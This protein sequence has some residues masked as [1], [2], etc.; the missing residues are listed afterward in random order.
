MSDYRD[1]RDPVYRDPVQDPAYEA[2]NPRSAQDLRSQAYSPGVAAAWFLGIALF[3]GILIFAFGTGDNQQMAETDTAPPP[4]T[5]T[6]PANPPAATPPAP[7]PSPQPP[8][9]Q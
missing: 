1:P 8:A 2:M 9:N 4:A 6:Q 3:I 5:Q 7:S